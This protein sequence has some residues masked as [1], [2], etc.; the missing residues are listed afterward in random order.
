MIKS[1]NE[2][3]SWL[4]THCTRSSKEHLG[5]ASWSRWLSKESTNKEETFIDKPIVPRH[6]QAVAPVLLVGEWPQPDYAFCL[7]ALGSPLTVR[8]ALLATLCPTLFIQTLKK[9]R[10]S[11][12][13][14]GWMMVCGG[15]YRL[16]YYAF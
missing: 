1:V 11:R 7:M 3:A 6:S 13:V 12:C 2:M 15:W 4:A 5:D 14:L 16:D 10:K 8:S 9:E